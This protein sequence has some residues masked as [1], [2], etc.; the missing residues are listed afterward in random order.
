MTTTYV[1]ATTL[2]D[3]LAAMADGARPIAGGTDLVVG[4]RQ[5][6]KPLPDSLVGIHLL[7]ELRTIAAAPDGVRIGALVSHE[8]II[9][10]ATIRTQYPGLADASAIVGS[11]ATRAQGTLGGNVMTASPAMDTGAPLLCFGALAVLQSSTGTRS[12][13]MTEL[14][15]GPGRTVATPDE[16]L[17]AIELPTVLPGTSSC[18]VRLEYRRQMEIAI[19]GSGSQVTMTDGVISDARVAMTAVSATIARVPAA[20]AALNGSSGDAASVKAAADAVAAACTPISD[21]RGSADYRRA[22]V[23]VITRR[24]ITAAIARAQGFDI[25]IP[26]SPA[27]HGA[28]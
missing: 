13:P 7:D 28:R 10:D 14:W 8:Q 4:A 1:A 9:A 26:A 20:E 24:A 3:A 2:T 19:V 23:A 16:L 18:Y 17:V 6:K 15:V 25:P 5:G 21:V 27:L 12:V 22:M 11:Y